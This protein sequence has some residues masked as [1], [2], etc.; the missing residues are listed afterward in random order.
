MMLANRPYLGMLIERCSL[1][2]GAIEGG[3]NLDYQH[4]SR[5]AHST[6]KVHVAM[7]TTVSDKQ[8]ATAADIHWQLVQTSV[9]AV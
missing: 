6:S 1:I 7:L 5:V 9:E 4:L 8:L 2:L 3:P